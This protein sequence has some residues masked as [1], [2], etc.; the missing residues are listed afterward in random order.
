LFEKSIRSFIDERSILFDNDLQD[1]H[2]KMPL[3]TRATSKIWKKA[4]AKLDPKIAAIP[5][6]NTGISP[7]IPEFLEW[8]LILIRKVINKTYSLKFYQVPHPTYT[9]GAWSNFA[10]LIK[11]NEKMKK[12]LSNTLGDS[13]CL[14]PKI[15]NIQRIEEMF[16]EHLNGKTDYTEFLFLLLTF[17]RW[18]KK[19]GIKSS[20]SV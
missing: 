18:H 3:N 1:L 8:G 13:E 20:R 17:G 16:E 14:N 4:I 19:Y 15:F 2:L 7:L 6:S 10:E 12:L 5:N 11:Y 9:Q